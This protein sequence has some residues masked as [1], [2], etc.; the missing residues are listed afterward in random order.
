MVSDRGILFSAPMVRALLD[1][2][3]SQTRRLAKVRKGLT[4][5]ELVDCGERRQMG[6]VTEYHVIRDML[7][8]P[9]YTPGDRLYV[10]EAHQFRGADYGDSGGEIEWFR[11]YGSGGPAD[12]WD[13][14]FPPDWEPSRHD[15]ARLLADDGEQEGDG[16]KGFVTKLRPS[17]HMPRWASRLTL[18]V[19]DVRVE[20]VQAI[21][22]ADAK[23]EGLY[24]SL[25]DDADREW[26]A[27]YHQEQSGVA[28]SETDWADFNEGTWMAPGVRQGWGLSKA[29][30]D[31]DQWAPTPQFGFQLLWNS[32][33]TKPGETWEANPWVV[34]ISFDVRH[35]NIDA[36]VPA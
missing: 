32:L 8:P 24:K 29:E 25:P 10:R 36:Q 21:R 20:R 27:A 26:F 5:G 16:I 6:P 15:K 14:I 7:A 18:T 1:G 30:R 4:Y 35:G 9:P 3:K 31:R 22:E 34:A 11:V 13:P 33:H 28:P 19:T 17:M 2:R 12:N 23:A